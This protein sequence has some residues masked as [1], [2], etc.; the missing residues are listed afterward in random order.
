MS[1]LKWKR[2]FGIGILSVLTALA[3][4]YGY[5]R[6]PVLVET[7]KAK[8]G[9]F[10][11]TVEEEG[12]TRVT[13]RYL[14][15]APVGGFAR[16]LQY[17]VGDAVRRG[18]VLLHLEPQRSSV[19]DSRTRAE[20]KARVQAAEAALQL[21]KEQKRSAQADA[22][23]WAG[24]LDRIEKLYQSGDLP[25]EK[26]DQ[27]VTEASRARAG[28]A[29]AEQAILQA[30]SNLR[31]Q[32]A[33]LAHSAAVST[34]AAELVA[35]P[36]PVDGRILKV[37]HE[38]EGVIQAGA[39]LIE[40]AD[41]RSL[42]VVV[43]LLSADAVKVR[44]GT[45]VLFDRWGG[46][47]PLEGKVRR[48]EPTAFTKISALGVE[49]QRVLVIVDFT[50]PSELWERL[51]D[52]Y[53]VEASF[54]LWEQPDVLQVPASALFRYQEGWAVFVAEAGVARRRVVEVGKR[55]GLFAQ[56]ISG[57]SQDESVITHPDETIDDGS[58]VKFR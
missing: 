28:L 27:A 20:A 15:S 51:G 44:P 24:Q 57:V 7:V 10:R 14:V 17:K 19:L 54:I 29:S 33:V 40:I 16:R 9:L 56:I 39:P 46:E 35:V 47:T 25:K 23:Y 13:D 38:S 48:V 49:E 53:R 11:V 42:E 45:P 26:Y 4:G 36:S 21:S 3:I 55:N 6:Q 5:R 32:Q 50:S 31:A 12:R 34:P 18:Q 8:R 37:I 2:W 43:E 22:E 58:P 41:A 52:A 1:P 30:Q